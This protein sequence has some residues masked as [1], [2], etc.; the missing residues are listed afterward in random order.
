MKTTDCPER[1]GFS[2]SKRCRLLFLHGGWNGGGG[3][4]IGLRRLEVLRAA[5]AAKDRRKPRFPV[6]R[7]NAFDAEHADIALLEICDEMRN[8]ARA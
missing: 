2:T 8:R 6:G 7:I 5:S 3:G 1:T 4:A